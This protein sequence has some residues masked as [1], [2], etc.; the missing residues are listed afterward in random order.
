MWKLVF[1]ILSFA[2]LMHCSKRTDIE[3]FKEKTTYFDSTGY[4][5]F[6]NYQIH[7]MREGKRASY[8]VSRYDTLHDYAVIKLYPESVIEKNFKSDTINVNFVN[9]FKMIG[10]HYLEYRNGGIR[11][12]FNFD[13]KNFVLFKNYNGH[14]I[15]L[16]FDTT[17]SIKIDKNW[18]YFV[19]LKHNN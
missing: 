19:F 12:D 10:C 14:N 18:S 2:L 11:L 17:N 16:P 15:S 5:I 13:N 8:Q 1:L 4:K 9:S 6:E 3:I 7:N